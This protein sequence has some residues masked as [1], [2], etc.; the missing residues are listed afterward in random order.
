MT[1]SFPAR[2]IALSLAA[3]AFLGLA[4]CAPVT[5]P[6]VQAS[7][8][9]GAQTESKDEAPEEATKGGARGAPIAGEAPPPVSEKPYDLV[10]SFRS[11]GQG[12]DHAARAR[13]DALF[14]ATPALSRAHG[15]W[16]RE[17]EVDECA[18][19]DR[20]SPADRTAFVSRVRAAMDGAKNVEIGE[21]RA[22]QHDFGVAE[23]RFEL[24]VEFF[25]P[26]NGTDA[27]AEA[28]LETIA[29]A[30]PKVRRASYPW[31][32]EG[33]HN[34]CFDFEGNQAARDDFVRGIKTSVSG[35]TRVRVHSD[36]R[37]SVR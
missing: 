11:V 22:C 33:E 4:A 16:G 26:G 25:S 17:G 32:K 18:D 14:D 28:A 5:P 2:S 15:R 31:G 34:E 7:P 36:A 20:L 23:K 27:K 1:V 37:C 30:W 8:G 21:H 24:V 6:P 10:V 9:S 19:L 29:A 12:T 35:S 13:L 3:V